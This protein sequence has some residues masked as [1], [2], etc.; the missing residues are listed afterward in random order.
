[1]KIK[2]TE[3]RVYS[4]QELADGSQNYAN[5]F[6]QEP[7]YTKFEIYGKKF[8]KSLIQADDCKGLKLVNVIDQDGQVGVALIPVDRNGNELPYPE[9]G[10]ITTMDDDDPVKCPPICN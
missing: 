2:G 9:E 1:M 3:K 4:K 7:T 8:I 10:D 6:S 5:S